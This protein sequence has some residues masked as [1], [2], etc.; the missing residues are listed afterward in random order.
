MEE[1]QRHWC[2]TVLLVLIIF[3]GSG[4][5]LFYLYPSDAIK[6]TYPEYTPAWFFPLHAIL[7]YI[8]FICAIA[9]FRWQ[10]WGFYGLCFVI[11]FDIIVEI[12]I[13][14]EI[15]VIIIELILLAILYGVL[16]IGKER[17]AWGQLD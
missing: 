14:Y 13:G 5:T 16:H 11:V 9:L 4:R 8:N 6:S 15:F 12:I 2:L 17:A 3:E 1:K 10:K 7:G